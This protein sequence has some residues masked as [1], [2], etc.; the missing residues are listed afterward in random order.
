MK[1]IPAYMVSIA[2]LLYMQQKKLHISRNNE[3][4]TDRN[5]LAGASEKSCLLV[6]L[7]LRI[8]TV[9]A[10]WMTMNKLSICCI[11]QRIQVNLSIYFARFMGR[12][13]YSYWLLSSVA[14]PYSSRSSQ[15]RQ[16]VVDT[17]KTMDHDGAV[18]ILHC[19]ISNYVRYPPCGVPNLWRN[20]EQRRIGLVAAE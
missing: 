3:K 18:P 12:I 4:N 1:L 10:E 5:S 19:T 17:K 15:P 11:T 7:S 8:W 6:S 14:H 16:S 13:G 9:P 2:T 20:P